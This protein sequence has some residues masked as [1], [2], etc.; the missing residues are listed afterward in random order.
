MPPSSAAR[1]LSTD[2]DAVNKA[3]DANLVTSLSMVLPFGP[4]EKQALLEAADSTARAKLLIAFLEMSAFGDNS[5]HTARPHELSLPPAA[6][7]GFDRHMR[8]FVDRH[9]AFA[10]GLAVDTARDADDRGMGAGTDPPD[11]QIRDARIAGPSTCSRT[12]ASRCG[13]LVS[14]STAAVSR[15]RFHAQIA[16]TMPPTMPMTGSSQTQPR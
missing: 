4:A 11:V 14:S 16:I 5:G 15:R 6:S 10:N 1:Q 8:E 12:S 3:A 13:S 9:E 2:W 7:A